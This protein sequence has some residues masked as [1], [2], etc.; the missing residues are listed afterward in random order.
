M[1]TPRM[2]TTFP[3]HGNAAKGAWSARWRTAQPHNFRPD[4]SGLCAPGGL[5]LYGFYCGGGGS[6]NRLTFVY[7]GVFV[8]LDVTCDT[9]QRATSIAKSGAEIE[10]MCRNYRDVAYRTEGAAPRL[11]GAVQRVLSQHLA[12]FDWLLETITLHYAG[13]AFL[14]SSDRRKSWCISR[15]DAEVYFTYYSH[16]IIGEELGAEVGLGRQQQ[17]LDSEIDSLTGVPRCLAAGT[18]GGREGDD[19]MGSHRLRRL[20]LCL[21]SPTVRCPTFGA[22]RGFGRAT[23]MREETST[24]MMSTISS[25]TVATR[26]RSLD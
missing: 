4:R 22:P 1:C 13:S 6:G 10:P 9:P 16:E 2:P 15:A 17:E 3:L 25:R 8:T 18:G 26:Q 11:I 14:A 7:M 21:L 5:L 19:T 24:C 20:L 12:V 23:R